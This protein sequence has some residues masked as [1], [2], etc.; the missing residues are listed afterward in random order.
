[1]THFVQIVGV[2]QCNLCRI[3]GA[4]GTQE[5]PIPPLPPGWRPLPP[6][7][8]RIRRGYAGLRTECP[9]CTQMRR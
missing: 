2:V 5:A 4:T 3:I 6:G 7:W 8:R 1:M 9:G